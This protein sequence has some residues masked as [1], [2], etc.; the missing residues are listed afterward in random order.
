MK[1]KKI[2]SLAMSVVLSISLLIGCSGKNKDDSDNASNEKA[3][4]K[5]GMITDVAGVNDQSFNQS[6][7]EGLQKAKEELGVEVTY[8]ESKQDSDY[9]TNIETFVD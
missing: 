9:A 1:L 2:V 8:L 4:L 7:W 5:I 3:I 6:A